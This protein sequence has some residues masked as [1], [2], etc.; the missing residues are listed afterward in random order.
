[1]VLAAVLAAL[2]C[3]CAGPGAAGSE[4]PAA[5]GHPGSPPGAGPPALTQLAPGRL[6]SAAPLGDLIC[7]G[8]PA[9]DALGTLLAGGDVQFG[10]T[11]LLISDAGAKRCPAWAVYRLPT[12]WGDELSSLTVDLTGST[13][14]VYVGVSDYGAGKWRWERL[15]P[16][17]GHGLVTIPLGPWAMRA[18][19]PDGA[20]FAAVVACNGGVAQF[21]GGLCETQ[22]RP[23]LSA[24]ATDLGPCPVRHLGFV[25]ASVYPPDGTEQRLYAACYD[26]AGPAFVVEVDPF[27]GTSRA[28]AAPTAD[29]MTSRSVMGADHRLYFAMR[30]SGTWFSF[31]PETETFK[32][33]GKPDAPGWIYSLCAGADG[34]IWGASYGTL[35]LTSYDSYEE[36]FTTE[37]PELDTE[38]T[39]PRDLASWH[40]RI[41]AGL[42]PER[43]SV[44]VFDPAAPSQPQQFLPEAMRKPGWAEIY[45]DA[46]SGDL[47]LD[48][49][50]AGEPSQYFR[51]TDELALE[52]VADLSARL[53]WLEQSC[54]ML[55]DGEMVWL[56]GD[57][58]YVIRFEPAGEQRV[59]FDCERSSTLVFKLWG[60]PEGSVFGATFNCPHLFQLDPSTDKMQDL[61]NFTHSNGQI[62]S[63]A[64]LREKLYMACYPRG[65]LTVY[66]PR[67]PFALDSLGMA[68][69]GPDD[70]PRSLGEIGNFQHRPLDCIAG[71][72]G[73]L[74][75]ASLADYGSATGALTAYDVKSGV[76]EMHQPFMGEAITGLAVVGDEL[77]ATST[78][79]LFRWDCAKGEVAFATTTVA[80]SASTNTRLAVDRDGMLIGMCTGTPSTLWAFDPAA[81]SIAAVHELSIG[82]ALNMHHRTLACG[83]DGLVY[84]LTQ[85]GPGGNHLYVVDPVTFE[86]RTLWVDETGYVYDG[87]AFHGDSLYLARGG[88]VLRISLKR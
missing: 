46:A 58:Q 53:D 50:P 83:P 79:S 7:A 12:Y 84:G 9:R 77:W 34:R 32:D 25:G 61:G 81:L 51:I 59:Y 42:G 63:L 49:S 68:G 88:H 71:P 38:N 21:Q 75:I 17:E 82:V 56:A 3:A 30:E 18:T 43:A 1:M 36:R 19:P 15:A 41:F 14:E 80:D 33:L 4:A 2:A 57:N 11:A 20:S 52:S 8:Q 22:A 67:Q 73:R 13:G 39:F 16:G 40:G 6:G 26:Y 72:D 28:F 85:N 66:D 23:P 54:P 5:S 35:A 65:G 74:Y 70:N 45:V 48:Y 27:R 60:T 24:T 78:R 69:T 44:V 55:A 76:F 87:F 47:L 10:D 37:W 64:A 62:F 31:D 86:P 29:H